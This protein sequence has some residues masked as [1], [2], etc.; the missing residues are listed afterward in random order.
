MVRRSYFSHETL[1]GGDLL[2]RLRRARY[3][4]RGDRFTVGENLAWGASVVG[5]PRLIVRAWMESPEH[6]ANV[7]NRRFR[8][9]GLGV[10]RGAPVQGQN[11]AAT[12]TAN[13]GKRR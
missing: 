4:R 6:R 8:E 12:Y 9:I 7:L 1:G 3:I 11:G 13:F 10:V 2:S 5:T